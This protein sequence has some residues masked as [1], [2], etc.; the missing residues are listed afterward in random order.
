[1]VHLVETLRYKRQGRGFEF[2]CCHWPLYDRE[3]D[4]A[5]NRNE[6][7][8]YFLEGKGGPC[9]GLTIL[10]P[11]CFDCLEIREPEPSG[12]LRACPGLYRGCF[13]VSRILVKLTVP[14]S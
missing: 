6:Y 10:Q 1:V 14:C 8:E 5:S 4:S 2:R 7:Q 12:A 13:T 9:V 11:S 3:I